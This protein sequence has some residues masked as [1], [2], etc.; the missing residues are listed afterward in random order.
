MCE[1]AGLIPN[2]DKL[3]YDAEDSVSEMKPKNIDTTN[4]K[5]KK[6]DGRG[7][8]SDMTFKRHTTFCDQDAQIHIGGFVDG[9]Q[10]FQFKV[11]YRE[12]SHH[13]ENQLKK[14]LPNGDQ[15]TQ[16][17]RTMNFSL[18]QIK[19]C[20][21]VVLTYLTQDLEDYRGYM[22]KTLYIYLTELQEL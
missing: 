15:P 4:P 2:S 6:L 21:N 18:T 14:R 1:V 17:L 12:M 13:F 11:P 7:N 5:A 19:Q 3:G 8:Y 22:S 9:K 10:V 20:N 16:Y